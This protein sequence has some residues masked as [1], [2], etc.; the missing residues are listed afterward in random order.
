MFGGVVWHAKYTLG[1]VWLYNRKEELYCAGGLVYD[2]Y[3]CIFLELKIG[4][5][6]P[7][8][9]W[10]LATKYKMGRQHVAPAVYHHLN[11]DKWEWDGYGVTDVT[12]QS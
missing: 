6:G 1:S 11:H 7:E 5:W 10:Y 2:C 12:W 3:T 9:I 4:P 8:L